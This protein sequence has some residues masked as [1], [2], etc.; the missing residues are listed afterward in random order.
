MQSHMMDQA[1]NNAITYLG[2]EALH[3]LMQHP[4]T[5]AEV[6]P[7]I[8]SA[9]SQV[10]H[11]NR[12]R[13]THQQGNPPIVMK[14]TW[15]ALSLSSDQ[16]VDPRKE[17]PLPAIAAQIL[18]TQKAATHHQSYQGNPAL[19][20]KRKQSPAYMKEDV[21]ALDTT[22]APKGSLKDIYK[23]FNGEGEQIRAFM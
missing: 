11:P 22:K 9:Y 8:S 3:P 18:L 16:R 1:I 12:D 21:K 20:P 14:T 2:A 23:V 5:I 10:H 17:R 19:N 6:A 13:K 15:M 7:V 4:L